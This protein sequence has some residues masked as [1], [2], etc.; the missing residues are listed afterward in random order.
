M[1]EKALAR[2]KHDE[3][4]IQWGEKLESSFE[5]MPEKTEERQEEWKQ[6]KVEF[7]RR[8]AN[9]RTIVADMISQE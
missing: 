4:L 7:M 2:S 8:Y 1:T 6:Q 3:L 5:N 9:K